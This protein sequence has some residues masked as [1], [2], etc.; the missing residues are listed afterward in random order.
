VPVEYIIPRTCRTV[1]H[2]P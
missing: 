1:K 2:L